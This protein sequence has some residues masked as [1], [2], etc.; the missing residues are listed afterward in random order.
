MKYLFYDCECANSF[1]KVSK[2]CSLGYC[3]SDLSFNLINK[4]DIIINPEA[5]FDYHLYNKKFDV[6]LSYPKKEFY[7]APNFKEYYSTIKELF[8]SNVI[9]F[10]FSIDN[11]IKF[12]LDAITR[13]E[14][15]EFDFK[16]LDVQTI[17]RLYSGE[18]LN[19]SLD[20]AAHELLIDISGEKLHKSDDDAYMTM[21]VLQK[22]ME[23]LGITSLPD[24]MHKYSLN[25]GT[26][27]QFKKNKEERRLLKEKKSK[28][29]LASKEK[30]KSLLP[31]YSKTKESPISTKYA[32]MQFYFS[33]Q[34]I[35]YVQN[36][37]NAQKIIFDNGGMTLREGNDEAIMIVGHKENR[38][39]LKENNIK[40][41]EIDQI[42]R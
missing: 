41:I 31:L 2:I 27:Q 9:V 13:Y 3:L 25:F 38:D 8:T 15:P 32:G 21:L 12:I 1:D 24:L 22:I 7:N 20:K 35:K 17:Y 23:N 6:Q 36:A 26:L 30:L 37:I 29:Y 18:Q 33:N 16:Y 42:L 39:D 10:G 19:T 4:E 28:E 5:P 40:Y 11:D 14:L 34:V